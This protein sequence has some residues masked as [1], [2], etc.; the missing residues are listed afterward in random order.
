MNS[1]LLLRLCLALAL[2]SIGCKEIPKENA[3]APAV[4]SLDAAQEKTAILA[5]L[6][7]ETKAAFTRD[8]EGWQTYWLQ[9]P[10]VSKTYMQFPDSSLVET[11]GWEEING[12]VKD[13]FTI[14]PE[15]EPVPVPL[16]DINVRL[17]GSGAWVTYEQ[18]DSLRGL[19]RETRLMEK[20][21]G[22]WKIAGMHTTIY[23]KSQ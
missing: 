23:G 6:N 17:Y 2:L 4:P 22:Q 21:D 14:H 20:V 7:N 11:L 10:F 3:V 5:T 1:K 16:T 8:Y 18:V 9:E 19:K 15:P 12:F 13:Y